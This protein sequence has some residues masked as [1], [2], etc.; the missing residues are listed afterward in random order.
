[1]P[2]ESALDF[3]MRDSRQPDWKCGEIAGQF[4]LKGGYLEGPVSELSGGW[5]TRLKLAALLLHEPNLLML[6]EPTNFLDLRTQI[7]LE[8]FL[9]G[10]SK[11]CLIVSHDRTFLEAT[12]EQTL[13]LARGKLTLYSGR[14]SAY[15]QN[16]AERQEHDRRVN[17]ATIAKQRQLKKFIDKNRAN[18]NTASQARSKAKQLARLEL[19]ELEMEERTAHIRTPWWNLERAPCCVARRS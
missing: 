13:D 8:H 9:R 17:A 15:L 14:V 11:A 4:E 3:L 2:G 1:M 10:F 6:D 7:L 18:A 12:C 5:Q 19:N 16:R